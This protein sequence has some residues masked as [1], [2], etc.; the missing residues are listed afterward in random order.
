MRWFLSY[1]AERDD[2]GRWWR[3][4]FLTSPRSASSFTPSTHKPPQPIPILSPLHR[5]VP[6]TP[7]FPVPTSATPLTLA[8][9][10]T[11]NIVAGALGVLFII[12][13][14]YLINQK[15]LLPGIVILGCF[16]LFILWLVGLIVV[17]IE[18]WGPQGNVN[19]NCQLY[20]QN[21]Q[22]VGQSLETLAWLQQNNICEY[23][24]DWRGDGEGGV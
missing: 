16:I 5:H 23:P 6:L 9:Y 21:Q 14:L 17:S 13:M 24:W 15:S 8:R 20:V 18:L 4:K 12:I 2:G 3:E 7:Q 19:G 10:F 11:Y 22:S 1:V